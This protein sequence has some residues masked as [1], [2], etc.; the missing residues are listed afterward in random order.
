[1][2]IEN[3]TAPVVH[4]KPELMFGKLDFGEQTKQKSVDA[5]SLLKKV[6]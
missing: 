5:F 6:F 1:M 2:R 3:T 4:E